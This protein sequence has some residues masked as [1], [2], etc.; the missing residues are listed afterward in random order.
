MVTWDGTTWSVVASPDAANSTQN[1]PSSIWCG[2][3]TACMAVGHAKVLDLSGESTLYTETYTWDGHSW[4]FVL[5]PEVVT[6]A[7]VSCSDPAA[8]VLVGSGLG[9]GVMTWEG[10]SWGLPAG[11][12]LPAQQAQLT[13]VA[14]PTAAFCMAVGGAQSPNGGIA[15]LAEAGTTAAGGEGTVQPPASTT[16]TTAE[17]AT[18]TT[19]TPP[20]VAAGGRTAPPTHRRAGAARRTTGTTPGLVWA[21]L[22]A[23][24]ALVLGG[25]LFAAAQLYRA[26][27]QV[28]T[29]GVDA[30]P[31]EGPD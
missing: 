22:G 29:A 9:L 12:G 14:C 11:T 23:G 24:G 28:R 30:L 5:S 13:S 3:P 8:C 27:R 6:A 2:S 10:S 31:G 15:P 19:S 25:V 16:T 17:S 20:V 7:A 21:A 18:T 26:R 4:S 1:V